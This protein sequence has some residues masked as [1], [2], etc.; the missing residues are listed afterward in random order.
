MMPDD[1]RPIPPPGGTY[2][3]GGQAVAR[4]GYGAMQL[5]HCAPDVA[6][7]AAL[8][9]RAIEL[10][11]DHIDTAQ[12]Y[13]DGFVNEAIRTVLR[14]GDAVV[15]ASKVGADFDRH[16]KVPMK[17][18]Q[19]P[20]QLRASLEAN[21][22]SLGVEHIP[23]VNLRR[24]DAGPGL[25]AEGDQ[26]VDI[27]DQMAA[28][29]AM[30]DEGKIGA[31]GLS[32]VNLGGVRRALPAGVACVQNAYSLV[33][34]RSEDL[35]RAL[36]RQRDRLGAFLSARRRDARLTEGHRRAQRDRGRRADERHAGSGRISLAAEAR[37]QHLADPGN[38]E[39]RPSRREP[40]RRL[41]RA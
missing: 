3:L 36:P 2:R 16:G 21:L 25:V 19:R 23:L 30:R 37:S 5:R 17:L 38:D 14:P 12:F 32:A 18:A 4:L 7:A 9:R 33:D 24:A 39:L 8:L 28:M 27:D 34:R 22:V 29:I 35:L 6:A 13:G 1:P 20:E 26:M 31:I 10:G 41:R 11:V 15:V 40:G